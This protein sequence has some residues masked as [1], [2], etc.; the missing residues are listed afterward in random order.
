MDLGDETGQRVHR[1]GT[2]Y[3]KFMEYFMKASL[4][5]ADEEMKEYSK[6]PETTHQETNL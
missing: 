6:E 4:W 2:T 3:S 1:L 5:T